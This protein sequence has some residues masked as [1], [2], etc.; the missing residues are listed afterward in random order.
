MKKIIAL[1]VL[2]MAVFAFAT[3]LFTAANQKNWKFAD[4]K[5]TVPADGA[6]LKVNFD[7][8]THFSVNQLKIEQNKFYVIAVK[9]TLS[10]G[11]TMRFTFRIIPK[12]SGR[13]LLS[14]TKAAALK[15]II[16]CR[17]SS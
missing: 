5:L 7:Q 9:G 16:T 4:S 11:A 12:A 1:C 6:A 10:K 3:E 15:K 8:K 17:S 13:M 14:M 2:F